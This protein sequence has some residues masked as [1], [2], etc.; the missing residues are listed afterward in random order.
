M[1]VNVVVLD[2]HALI[3]HAMRLI[4]DAEEGWHCVATCADLENAQ[5]VL[6]SVDV[7]LMICDLRLPSGNA[8]QLIRAHA[9]VAKPRFL[10]SSGVEHEVFSPICRKAGAH[11]F[12][13]KSWTPQAL[14]E[15]ARQV[16]QADFPADGWVGPRIEPHFLGCR[17]CELSDRELEILLEFGKGHSTKKIARTLYVSE[18]TIESHR[19]RIKQKMALDSKDHLVQLATE[20]SDVLGD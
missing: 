11:G 12:I 9:Q 17:L 20:L 13:P 2:D 8:L 18:K 19:L 3:C 6:H 15:A 16:V 7:D 1:S 4:I 5:A 14:M 10:V